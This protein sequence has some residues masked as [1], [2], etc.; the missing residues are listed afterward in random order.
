MTQTSNTIKLKQIRA[1]VNKE[2]FVNQ[3]L[4]IYFTKYFTHTTGFNIND[5]DNL[6][7]YFSIKEIK[8]NN[9]IFFDDSEEEEYVF[10]AKGAVKLIRKYDT[11]SHQV[12]ALLTEKDTNAINRIVQYNNKVDFTACCTENTILLTIKEDK[13]QKLISA[14]PIFQTFF[15]ESN[16]KTVRFLQDRVSVLQ[17]MSAF[18]RY[19]DLCK[20]YPEIIEFIKLKYNYDPKNKFYNMWFNN[21]IKKLK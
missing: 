20:S 4:S 7:E 6:N 18:E 15:N 9:L 8:K 17:M 3:K 16:N 19:G 14:R 1:M 13:M 21:I 10:L 12:L 5:T 11:S 2:I